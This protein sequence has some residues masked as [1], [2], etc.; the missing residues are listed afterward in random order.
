MHAE[1]FG[2]LPLRHFLLFEDLIDMKADLGAGE[3]LIAVVK[4]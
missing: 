2:D 3:Q 4:P 1:P